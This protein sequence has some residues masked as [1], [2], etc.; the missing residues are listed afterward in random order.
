MEEGATASMYDLDG[1]LE[2]GDLTFSTRT[3]TPKKGGVVIPIPYSLI[4]QGR[5]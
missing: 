2:D 3:L 4:L 1:E 5:P